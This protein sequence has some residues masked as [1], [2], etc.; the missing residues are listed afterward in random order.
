MLMPAARRKGV[1][2]IKIVFTLPNVHGDAIPV[3]LFLKV[4]SSYCTLYILA[5]VKKMMWNLLSVEHT[6]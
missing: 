6:S 3:S 2:E 4:K 1:E 5:I